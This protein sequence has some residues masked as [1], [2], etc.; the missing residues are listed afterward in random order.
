MLV[1]SRKKDESIIISVGEQTV[2]VRVLSMAGG[3]V[4]L[5]I[6]AAEEVTIH[7]SEVWRRRCEFAER[8]GL[9]LESV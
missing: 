3:K 5:G 6:E 7:R 4:R 9:P 2:Q 1:L 8:I